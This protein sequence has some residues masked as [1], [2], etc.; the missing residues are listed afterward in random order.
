LP[1]LEDYG[2]LESNFP[3]QQ[4]LWQVLEHFG[5][6]TAHFAGAELGS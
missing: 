4:R 6:T 3:L 5:I 1:V 2:V